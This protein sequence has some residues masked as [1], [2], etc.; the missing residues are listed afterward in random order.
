[1]YTVYVKIKESHSITKKMV[2]LNYK[3]SSKTDVYYTPPEIIELAR[4][5][6]GKIDLDPASSEIGNSH[7]KA[8]CY[9]S[10]QDNGL[11]KPWF[12]SVFLN[13][14]GG[15]IKNQ[16]SLKV[17]LTHGLLKYKEGKIDQL[18]CVCF[19]IEALRMC[20]DDF[21]EL[22][23]LICIPRKR[24][25]Y[26]HHGTSNKQPHDKPFFSSPTH[27]SFLAYLGPNEELFRSHFSS[28]GCVFKFQ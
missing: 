21:F 15:R 12:G 16:S 23:S 26:Y 5:V 14:P 17:W 20:Q 3:F 10:K 1:M 24:I 25:Q 22:K 8:T 28:L 4:Q 2:D 19:N 7:V 6:L 13:P 9:Y 11:S 18:L 27:A